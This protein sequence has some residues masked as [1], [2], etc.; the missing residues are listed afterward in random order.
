MRPCDLPVFLPALIR[1]AVLLMLILYLF[2]LAES[3]PNADQPV[4]SIFYSLTT[5]QI[6]PESPPPFVEVLDNLG[7]RLG[8]PN[9]RPDV[10]LGWKHINR[11]NMI[12]I[13]TPPTGEFADLLDRY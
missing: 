2:S 5:P 11:Y 9:E 13:T 1:H 10:P 8:S 4:V 12:I 6:N 3:A 7:L